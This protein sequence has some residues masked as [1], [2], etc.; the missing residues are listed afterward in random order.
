[1]VV[2]SSV[3]ICDSKKI[4]LDLAGDGLRQLVREHDDTRVL[5][6]GG[7]RLDVILD[8]LL[9]RFTAALALH[10]LDRRLDDLAAHGVRRGGNA[11]FEDVRK[12][13]DYVLDLGGTDPVARTLDHVIG[14]ADVVVVAVL[15]LP[16]EVAGVVDAAAPRLGGLLL[17]LVVAEEDTRNT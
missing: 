9:E 1:M 10:K 7:M 12:L 2:G 15:V 3:T 11:A 14:A 5:I 8:L 16:R 4:A 6:R 17:V 13:H